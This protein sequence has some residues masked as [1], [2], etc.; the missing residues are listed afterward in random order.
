MVIY[1]KVMSSITGGLIVLLVM[2]FF[3]VT[4]LLATQRIASPPN[5]LQ[6]SSSGLVEKYTL[7]DLVDKANYILVGRV[8]SIES[9]WDCNRT[10]IYTFV[11]ISIEKWVS[12]AID[13]QNIT[14]VVQGGKVGEDIMRSSTA[15]E[16]K[17]GEKV[18]L[19]LEG[20]SPDNLR[21]VGGFQ[22]KILIDHGKILGTETS[23]ETYITKI[24]AIMTKLGIN[25]SSR[26]KKG[27]IKPPSKDKTS[28]FRKNC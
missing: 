22:G 11:N 19:F 13:Y 21:V 8:S 17:S 18:V 6:S 14:V 7:E 25:S 15:P 5:P 9:Q 16:F 26:Q 2:G 27:T 4:V 28:A 20:D 12:R 1:M 3:G 10:R 23:L 24:K